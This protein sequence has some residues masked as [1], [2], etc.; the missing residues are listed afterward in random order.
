LKFKLEELRSLRI[1]LADDA[2]K[3]KPCPYIYLEII[4]CVSLA[5]FS[6]L[7][8]QAALLRPSRS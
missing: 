4:S 1:A 3:D 7:F 5:C 6:T 8:W 2:G